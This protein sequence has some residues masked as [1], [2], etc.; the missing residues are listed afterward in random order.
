MPISYVLSKPP[1][2]QPV[3]DWLN[4]TRLDFERELSVSSPKLAAIMGINKAGDIQ[5][6]FMPTIIPKAFAGDDDSSAIIGNTNNSHSKPSFIHTDTT[7]LGSVYVIDT[8]AIIPDE[9]RPEEPL[10]S[11]FLADT[12]YANATV[13]IGMALIPNVMPI[14][15]G[16]RLIEGCIHDA[17]FDDKMESISPIHLKWAK[18]FKEHIAQQENDGDDIIKIV[19]RLNKKSKKDVN[20]RFGTTGFVDSYKPD[21]CFFFTYTLSNGDK[22]TQHQAKLRDFFVGNPSPMKN[23]RPPSDPLQTPSSQN[24]FSG[25]PSPN[26]PPVAAAPA[27]AAPASAARPFGVANHVQF[28][29]TAAVP[30]PPPSII[31]TNG[32]TVQGFDPMLFLQQ[33][34]AKMLTPQPP[35]TIVVESRADKSRES[36]AKFN[37]NM[38]QLLLVAGDAD[39][40]LP[41]TFVNSRI[42]KYTQAMKN[43]LAQPTSVRSTQMVNILTTIFMEVPNDMAEMLSPLTTHKSMHHISKNFASALLS[44]NIQRSNLDSLNFETSSITI[45]SFVGQSDIA[46]VEAYREAEQIAKNEREF[47]FIESHRKVL[48]TTI[49]GLG[50]ITSMDCIVKICANVCCVITALFDIQPGNPVPLLYQV[51]IKMIGFIKHLDFIRWHADVRESVP[52]LP[53]IFLNMLHQVLAQLAGFSTNSVN[54]NLIELGDDGAK[55]ITTNIQ[56]I[57]KYVARFFDRMENHILEGTYPDVIPKFTP[58]DANPKYHIANVI[59]S[60]D[61][62]GLD[63]CKKVK[64]EASPPATP[65]RG[66]VQKKQK[67]KPAVGAKDFTKAGLFHCRDGFQ[68]GDLLPLDLSK[69]YCTFFCFHNKKCSKPN[70]ACD[71][72]HVGR[73]EKIPPKDQE[74]ILAHFHAG[75]EKKAWLDAETF[76]K[77]NVTIPEKYAYLLGDASGCKST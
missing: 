66:R 31:T 6:L 16:Q 32:A 36:E 59:A 75:K 41:G 24:S 40:F 11:K 62:G 34:S 27:A 33:L 21:S 74:K 52:Q 57:V 9:I 68:K 20:A 12:S 64:P 49:E 2:D 65:A 67:L 53:Y 10:P 5:Y 58:K 1:P 70:Q 48:K 73:W 29:T 17:D 61:Q 25:P 7:D 47:D 38:L 13:P 63:L 35:Q 19:D 39:L 4:W 76:A 23:P 71:F 50:K 69:K 28:A 43:I 51:S 42:P 30:A 8:Y 46:K 15:F 26:D 77:H 22:W 14:F 55:L 56:K 72:E 18:L 45:L 54:N 37:N 3:E 60:I 44:C